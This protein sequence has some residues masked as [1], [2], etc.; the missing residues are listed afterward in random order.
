MMILD[1]CGGTGSWS[2]P[3]ERAGYDVQIIDPVCNVSVETFLRQLKH[4]SGM[5]AHGIL[6]AP[7]CTEF[8]SAGARHWNTKDPVLLDQAIA[9]V[10]ACYD[11]VQLLKP[12]WWALENPTGRI[13]TCCPFLGE[14]VGSY[15]PWQ[16]GDSWIKLTHLWGEFVMPPKRFTEKPAAAFDRTHQMSE[17]AGRARLRAITSPHFAEA[18]FRSN[19]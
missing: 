7:P 8:S 4:S 14:K 5:R 2:L 9:I 17:Q 16:Y 10:R 1:L 15:H 12:K 19:L 6:A 13:G 18:F 3:Y 11:I